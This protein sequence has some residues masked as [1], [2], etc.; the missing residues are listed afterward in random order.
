MV[1]AGMPSDI[2]MLESVEEPAKVGRGPRVTAATARWVACT[3]G[4][5]IATMPA[6]PVADQP[7][8]DRHLV[9]LPARVFVRHRLLDQFEQP[10]LE[11]EQF[12]FRIRAHVDG[13]PALRR[14]WR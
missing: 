8:L 5:S 13:H 12:L 14:R 9:G 10:R 2:A 6:G 3:I 11:L 7:G 4:E 1:T